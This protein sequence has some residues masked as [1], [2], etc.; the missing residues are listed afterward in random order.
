[1]DKRIAGVVIVAVCVVVAVYFVVK[2][3]KTYKISGYVKTDGVALAGATVTLDGKSAVTDVNGYYEFTSLEG[4][5]SYS[6]SVTK[7]RYESHSETIQLGVEDKQVSE[8]TLKAVAVEMPLTEI[9]SAL[10]S[11]E[12]VP[13]DNVELYF[14]V[15]AAE[16]DNFAV[17]AVISEQT[18]IVFIFTKST[19]GIAVENEPYTATTSDERQAMSILVYKKPLSRFTG[20]KIVPFNFVKL[21]NTYSFDYYDGY[22]MYLRRWGFGSA[23][24]DASGNIPEEN[25]THSWI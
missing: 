22:D 14:C 8:I 16:N 24:L 10:A 7:S 3:A 13:A 21:N 4:S 11:R 2:P 12:G 25:M 9:T 17:G 15:Q 20:R 19:N 18:S 23:I 1:M 6:L 5:K